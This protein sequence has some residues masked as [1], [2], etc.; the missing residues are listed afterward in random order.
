MDRKR[1][2]LEYGLED[3][4]KGV[5][6][7]QVD[8][9]FIRLVSLTLNFPQFLIGDK[10]IGLDDYHLEHL[11]WRLFLESRN[12]HSLNLRHIYKILKVKERVNADGMIV[13][14]EKPRFIKNFYK[15]SIEFSIN[16]ND[17]NDLVMMENWN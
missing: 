16:V 6:M 13:E 9:F 2:S 5:T 15:S 10:G 3:I 4:K 11:L 8:D 14:F 17:E 12:M 1:L 7:E